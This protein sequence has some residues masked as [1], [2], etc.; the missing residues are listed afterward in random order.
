MEARAPAVVAVVVTTGLAPGLEGTLSTLAGQDYEELSVLVIANGEAEDTVSRVAAV[1]PNAFVK[2][3][4]DNLGFAAACNE[5]AVMVQ[6][7]AFLL[8]CHDDVLFYE[9]AVR[10]MV[11]TAFRGNAGVVTPKVVAYDDPFI[12]LHVGQVV[13]RFGAVHERV[14][15]G[16]IDHGQQDLERDVFVAPGGATL[17]R[18]DL[19]TTLRGFDPLIPVLGED[20]DLCWRAQV[21]GARIMIAPAAVVAHRQTVASGE[22]PV[23]AIGTRK[24]SRR[25]LLR[26]H[27]LMT[28]LTCWSWVTLLW[29][30]PLYAALDVAEIILSLVGR[31]TDRAGAIAGAWRW[32]LR[33]RKHVR[34]RRKELAAIR[35]LSDG[36]VARL[37]VGGATRL[38][39]FFVTLF[40]D[41]LD[42]ARGILP[43]VEVDDDTPAGETVGGVG[44]ASAFSE[45]ESF[46]EFGA[47]SA[48]DDTGVRNRWARLFTGVRSQL[49]LAGSIIVLWVF[50]ARNLVAAALPNVG[51]LAP[52]DSWW[53]TWRHFFASWS[54]N[55][56]GTGTPG[57]PGYGV[58]AFAG[59]FVFG[60]MG[61]LPRMALIFAVPFGA[62][63]MW[64]LLRG[65]VSNRARL[66]AVVAYVAFPVGVNLIARGRIDDLVVVAL[67]PFATRRI[68][69]ILDVPGFRRD[70][71]AAPV[72]FGRR[73]FGATRNGHVLVLMLQV[74]L[75]TAM[76]PA[77]LIAISLIVV[78]LAWSQW[79]LG[80]RSPRLERP[81]GLLGN[82]IG[83]TALLLLPMTFDTIAAG[84]QA[85]QLFGLA[86]SP[87]TGLGVSA[88]VRGLN[89][90]FG[91]G[92]AAWLLPLVALSSMV[93][94]RG[95]R[96]DFVVRFS[97]IGAL[98]LL[99]ATAVE[100]HWTGPFAP[101]ADVL[102][103]VIAVV[104]AVLVSGTVAA[105]ENDVA[106]ASFGW[107]QVVVALS[108]VAMV[109]AAVPL[110][111]ESTSG[112]FDLPTIG[113]PQ[114]LGSI[115]PSTLGGYRVLWLGNPSILP[116]PGWTVAPG[117]AAATTT[118]SIVSGAT[119]FTPPDAGASDDL[120]HAV[121]E[122]LHGRTA[123]LG[124][125]LAPSGISSIV[126]MTASAPS[127]ESEQSLT[128][129]NPPANLIP[130]LRAQGDLTLVTDTPGF[131]VFSNSLFHGIVAERTEPLSPSVTS[132]DHDSIVGWTPALDFGYRQG[133]VTGGTLLAGLAPSSA[134]ALSV[135]GKNVERSG[136][137]GWAATYRT[138]GGNAELVLH[139]L[140]LNGLL[141]GLT[142]LLWF[143]F[144]AGFGVLERLDG[145]TA[146][147]RRRPVPVLTESLGA[148][149]PVTTEAS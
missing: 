105:I 106:A 89:G 109:L 104:V 11:E 135:G 35:V 74:A 24:A 122:A 1:V 92:W 71:L 29:V 131:F 72:A 31:D 20:L 136:S 34:H 22:R 70:P 8:F 117:L 127:F 119:L 58:L 32:N 98:V 143:L 113:T 77:S 125:L 26:R 55:G 112:R 108:V 75:M 139:Q 83:G 68:L 137:L 124:Q 10:Q 99:V 76:A 69:L 147:L 81:W 66:A 111:A 36:D 44:F 61:V 30:L 5:A 80:R 19:F 48:V 40:Q 51:R 87:A 67:L 120:L 128:T 57:M 50:G 7:A 85:P 18:T 3:L 115:A 73:G 25:D 142:L 94:A 96:R 78:A 91:A 59:T 23:N 15:L 49:V 38:K 90:P 93:L 146:R 60:R 103:V 145:V 84:R 118:D 95:A 107:H 82:M 102:L 33:Q 54:P 21:A 126:V 41:G 2:V 6:G 100:R 43:P 129:V 116:V 110:L 14:E 101:D 56:V 12:L 53:S 17:I 140:P 64:R 134:F 149:D 16:E 42:R 45:D 123:R 65:V 144:A 13:D 133:H 52:L 130:A 86:Q 46:D 28:V 148:G 138:T 62:W 37:Q 4:D 27:Q 9:G 39:T 132:S 79:L 141:A 47:L 114:A 88:L 63:G 97:A 121:D